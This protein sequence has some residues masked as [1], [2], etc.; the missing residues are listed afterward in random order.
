MALPRARNGREGTRSKLP[1][2][3]AP[4]E[5]R[6]SNRAVLRRINGAQHG[7]R[8]GAAVAMTTRSWRRAG[9]YRGSRETRPPS[10][11]RGAETCPTQHERKAP[12]LVHRP[13]VR[14]CLP[15]AATRG[16]ALDADLSAEAFQVQR[17]LGQRRRDA[18]RAVK[19]LGTAVGSEAGAGAVLSAAHA[20]FARVRLRR[21]SALPPL[22][23]LPYDF[24]SI[25][26]S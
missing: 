1:A 11:F 16:S 4:E 26:A 10:S 22:R 3:A 5:P 15:S 14:N 13:L 2:P 17:L 25:S 9:E 12:E 8:R 19:I 24:R 23:L 21:S 7:G 18:L 20:G 6:A